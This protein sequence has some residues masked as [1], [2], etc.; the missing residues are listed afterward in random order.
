MGDVLTHRYPDDTDLWRPL[1]DVR[2]LTDYNNCLSNVSYLEFLY[3][4]LYAHLTS[5]FTM[6][7]MT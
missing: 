5:C 2:S 4:A 1:A 6:D 7:K 3:F